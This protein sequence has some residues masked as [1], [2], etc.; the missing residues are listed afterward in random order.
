MKWNISEYLIAPF[1]LFFTDTVS[2]ETPG[3]TLFTKIIVFFSFK[4][5]MKHIFNYNYFSIFFKFLISSLCI[6]QT[7][8]DGI[9]QHNKDAN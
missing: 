6:S 1:V 5:Q 3:M 8:N 2:C 9:H 4:I 7:N